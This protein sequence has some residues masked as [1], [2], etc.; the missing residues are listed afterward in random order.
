[1]F[2][3]R[4]RGTGSDGSK[5]KGG[6]VVGRT[7]DDLSTTVNTFLRFYPEVRAQWR[8]YIM[9][10]IYFPSD[11]VAFRGPG[12]DPAAISIENPVFLTSGT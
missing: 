7:N 2:D 6:C 5:S 11:V 9:G 3:N 4:G 10:A 8:P 1:M 12:R